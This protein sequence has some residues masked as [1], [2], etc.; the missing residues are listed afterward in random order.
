M[1]NRRMYQLI[2]NAPRTGSSPTIWAWPQLTEYLKTAAQPVAGP[3][4]PHQEPRPDPT[5]EDLPVA[6]PDPHSD[7]RGDAESSARRD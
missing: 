4:P 5:D 7:A 1:T 6:V 2:E 3:W